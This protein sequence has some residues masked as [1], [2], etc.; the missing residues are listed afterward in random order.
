M[1]QEELKERIKELDLNDVRNYEL[2]HVYQLCLKD[3]LVDDFTYEVI[4]NLCDNLFEGIVLPNLTA[5]LANS[6]VEIWHNKLDAIM[7]WNII[8]NIY[9]ER[10]SRKTL[11]EQ[12]EDRVRGESYFGQL[13]NI[14]FA[15]LLNNLKPHLRNNKIDSIFED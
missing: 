2:Y 8:S 11:L 13:N 4:D 5:E 15:T 3:M 9:S 10:K 1:E 6:I 12:Y 7:Q 14:E